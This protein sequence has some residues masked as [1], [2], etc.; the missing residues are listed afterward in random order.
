V[1]A[2]PKPL[3]L[4]VCEIDKTDLVSR[5]V[6]PTSSTTFDTNMSSSAKDLVAVLSTK[7][8]AT[9]AGVVNAPAGAEWNIEAGRVYLKLPKLDAAATFKVV[10]AK[11]PVDDVAKFNALLTGTPENL[12]EHTK[13]GPARWKETVTTKGEVS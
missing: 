12:Q 11:L 6:G 4:F 9:A 3:T 1:S 2:S 7:D 13:G 8:E 10:I 5:A